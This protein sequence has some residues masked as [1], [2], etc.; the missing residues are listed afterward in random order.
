MDEL[1]NIICREYQDSILLGNLFRKVQAK[2][3]GVTEIEFGKAVVKLV[4]TNTFVTWHPESRYPL[5]IDPRAYY[6]AIGLMPRE[7]DY[8]FSA[9]R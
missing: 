5:R 8:G 6:V 3:P 7:F 9:I 4:A 2:H 1:M